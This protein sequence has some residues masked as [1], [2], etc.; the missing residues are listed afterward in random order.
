MNASPSRPSI[1]A[2]CRTAS[3]HSRRT[4]ASSLARTC[5]A[6]HLALTGPGALDLPA[7]LPEPGLAIH[8]EIR[9]V[10]APAPSA[11]DL[12]WIT[13]Q[14]DGPPVSTRA[15]WIVVNGL[16]HHF[17]IV[18][19]E[20]RQFPGGPRLEAGAGTHELTTS[21]STFSRAAALDGRPVRLVDPA[22]AVFTFGAADRGKLERVDLLAGDPPWLADADGDGMSDEAEAMAGTDPKDPDSVLRFTPGARPEAGGGGFDGITLRF[23]GATGRRYVVERSTRVEGEYRA[24]GQELVSDG[25][26]TVF[27]DVE[28]RGAGPFFYRVRLR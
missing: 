18:P 22:Q 12:V 16:T 28:A 15:L 25:P 27:V 23:T 19:F 6:L 2:L 26:A 4:V 10:P 14:G 9:G 3:R 11:P 21:P 5:I 7:A 13:R 1:R 24:V 8:G 20:T 17:A